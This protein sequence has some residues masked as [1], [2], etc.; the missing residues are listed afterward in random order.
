MPVALIAGRIRFVHSCNIWKTKPT[1]RTLGKLLHDLPT[2]L[3]GQIGWEVQDHPILDNGI[4][5]IPLFDGLERLP[6]CRD[7]SSSLA[8][9]GDDCALGACE[10]ERIFAEDVKRMFGCQPSAPAL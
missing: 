2:L 7:F 1:K 9:V 6:A 8:H 3:R 10:L 4:C 5:A